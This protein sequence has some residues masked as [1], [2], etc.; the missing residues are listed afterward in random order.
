M[1]TLGGNIDIRT[2]IP[3]YNIYRDGVLVDSHHQIADLWSDGMVGFAL[4]C[5]FT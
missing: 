2:D 3:S 5:S 4:G 1:H